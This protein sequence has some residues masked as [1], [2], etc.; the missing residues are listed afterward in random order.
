M[1]SFKIRSKTE[2][3]KGSGIRNNYFK[4]PFFKIGNLIVYIE[5]TKD[6]DAFRIRVQQCYQI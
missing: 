4:M 6:T 5:N 1:S 3:E 2:A